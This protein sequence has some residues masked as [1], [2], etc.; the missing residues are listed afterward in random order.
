[1]PKAI[2]EKQIKKIAEMIRDWPENERFNWNNIC[3]SAKTILGYAPTRQAL[4][5]KV[6][7]KIAYQTKKKQRNDAAS[8]LEG[9]PRPQSI[10]DAINKITR[11]QQEND[12][13]R[14]ELDKMAELAQRFIY[15]A[16]IA[17]LSQQRLMEPLPK[18]RRD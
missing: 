7:L 2:T 13:L 12:T 3:V 4:S 10:Q 9:I 1:M 17:G 5:K 6:V 14:A 16:S 18:A 15:N 8:K 11:L